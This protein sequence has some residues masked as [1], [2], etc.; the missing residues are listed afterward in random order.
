MQLKWKEF[1]SETDRQVDNRLQEDICGPLE[2][3]TLQ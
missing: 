1:V 2:K 3:D